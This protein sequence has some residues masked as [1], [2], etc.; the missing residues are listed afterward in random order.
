MTKNRSEGTV[1]RIQYDHYGSASE[2]Y[3][4]KHAL[5]AIRNDEVQVRVKAAS[6]N[7][8]DWKQ[9]RGALKVVMGRRFPKGMGND[10]SGIVEA[11]GADVKNVKIGD[12][13]FG[14]VEIKSPGAFAEAVITKA[15]LVTRKPANIT[16][17]EAACLPISVSTAWAALVLKGQVSE[18]SRVLI[19]GCTGAVGLTAVQLAVARGAKVAGTCSVSSIAA[20][21]SA[22]VEEIYDYARQD[23]LNEA[24][25]FDVIFD[26]A[27]TLAVGKGL[28]LLH[29]KGKFIDINPGFGRIARG[30]LSPA[31]KLAFATMGFDQLPQIAKLAANSV[32]Q[33]KIGEVRPFEEAI[34]AIIMAESGQRTK[35]RI[36]I[37]F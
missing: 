30:C 35:G 10:F 2:M 18:K 9:R 32:I 23:R 27:G 5:G 21:K 14:T 16:F 25:K 26:T 33:P 34:Q 3:V 28:S 1:N 8:L 4:G 20:A 17:E 24:G 15:K 22:G 11:V 19:N 29:P 12:E 7:P 13:V 36:V 6:I 31:Y 37:T